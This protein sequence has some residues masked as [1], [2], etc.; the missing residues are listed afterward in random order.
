M[1][2][3]SSPTPM[4]AMNRHRSMAAA[5]CWNAMTAVASEYQTSETVKM[6][7]RPNRSAIAPKPTLPSH[8]P[9]NVQKT[10]KPM[11]L[12]AKK[13]AGRAVNRPPATSPGAI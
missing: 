5:L 13:P 12:G 11:P 2:T 10:K 9:A 8:M 4:A 3:C 1:V 6:E 7:R